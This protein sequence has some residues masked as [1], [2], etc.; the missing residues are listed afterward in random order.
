MPKTTIRRARA[1]DAPTLADLGARTFATT[2][3]HLYPAADLAAFLGATHTPD[4]V[5]AELAAPRMAAWLA[6][7]DGVAIGYALAGP[8]ALPH[9]EVTGQC[10]E[11]KRIYVLSDAQG[12]GLGARLMDLAIAWL[13]SAGRKAVWLGVWSENLAAQRFYVR[14][15]FRKVGEYAFHVGASVDREFIMRRD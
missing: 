13:D 14:N 15:G 8:C 1:D 11:L 3:G 6:E 2:F 5:A 4:K 9:P 10:G 12:E 7:R